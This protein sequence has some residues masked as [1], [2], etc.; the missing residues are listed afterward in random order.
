M[1]TANRIFFFFLIACYV[2]LMQSFIL[3]TN[4]GWEILY[5][6]YNRKTFWTEFF[7]IATL[8]GEWVGLVGLAIYLLITNRRALISALLAFVP[9]NFFLQYIKKAMDY[10]RPLLYFNQG[11]ISPIPDLTPLYKHSMPSGHTFTAFYCMAFLIFFY[12]LNRSWQALL[13]PIA[14]LVGVSRMY[15]MCHFKEDVFIGSILGILAGVLSVVI[16]EKGLKR[17]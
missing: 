14:I 2:I 10:P 6:C 5:F 17:I 13:F 15:L 9:I 12:N 3:M 11:E 8:L 7:K 1:L 16:Y 4:K